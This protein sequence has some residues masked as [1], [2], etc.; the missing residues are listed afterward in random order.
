MTKER[1]TNMVANFYLNSSNV[2]RSLVSPSLAES[3]QGQKNY[4]DNIRICV[5]AGADINAKDK[6]GQNVLGTLVEAT[7]F[8]HGV[9]VMQDPTPEHKQLVKG[10]LDLGA[11]SWNFIDWKARHLQVGKLNFPLDWIKTDADYNSAAVA[12]QIKT[13]LMKNMG[14]TIGAVLNDEERVQSR[15][16]L[17]ILVSAV[18]DLARMGLAELSRE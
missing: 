16:H 6:R 4:R 14:D 13:M 7:C 9:H 18:T 15:E 8:N 11:D 1:A 3:A 5:E 10:L 17:A 2:E 12:N